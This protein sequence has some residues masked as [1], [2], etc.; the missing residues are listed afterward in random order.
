MVLIGFPPIPQGFGPGLPNGGERA[1]S[2]FRRPRPSD[3]GRFCGENRPMAM[4]LK[5]GVA[6]TA[7]NIDHPLEIC[8]RNSRRWAP[9]PCIAQPEKR[10]AVRVRQ[11]SSVRADLQETSMPVTGFSPNGL[12]ARIVPRWPWRP[13]SS[14]WL[15]DVSYVQPPGTV[16]ANRIFTISHHPRIRVPPTHVLGPTKFRRESVYLPVERIGV[17]SICRQRHLSHPPL[18]REASTVCAN[19]RT[20]MHGRQRPMSNTA[21]GLDIVDPPKE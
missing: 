18:P 10:R 5:H 13:K 16:G 2:G 11:M 20:F 15:N 12:S 3:L 17:F 9:P 19:R 6:L 21:I 7:S 14:R 8:E 4:G 1:N